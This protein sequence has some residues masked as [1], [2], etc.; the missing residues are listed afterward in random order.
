MSLIAKSKLQFAYGQFDVFDPAV[1]DGGV[2]WT[3][4]HSQQGFARRGS[5]VSFRTLS[6]FGTAELSVFLSSYFR[7]HEYQRV[8]E[9]PMLATGGI[10]EIEGPEE[11]FVIDRKIEIGPGN[12]RLTAAQ[13]L[14][15][16]YDEESGSYVLMVDIFFEEV[17]RPLLNSRILVSDSDLSPPAVLMESAEIPKF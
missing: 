4:I 2:L 7:H 12:Y 13:R 15:D 8:V 5:Y 16:E 3:D 10:I 14:T 17:S 6:D 1:Y 11:A 9:V